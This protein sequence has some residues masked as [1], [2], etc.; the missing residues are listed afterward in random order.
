MPKKSSNPTGIII[1]SV[2][3]VLT[4]GGFGYWNYTLQ[5]SVI[6]TYYAEH[7][8]AYT[9]ASE[10]A[11]YA[12]PDL[13]I[14]IDVDKGEQVYVSFTCTA[15]II[16]VSSVTVMHF[17]VRINTDLILDS[18]VIVG[19]TGVSPTSPNV[20][21][22]ALQYQDD[23]LA[24]GSHTITIMTERECDGNIANSVLYIQVY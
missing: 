4:I 12:I 10:D 23:A 20:Y 1:L 16:A 15:S 2:L 17:L 7:P 8:T 9:T 3:L 18:E 24:A 11:W 14:T 22:V 21:S 6:K 19:Y 13:S 5:M